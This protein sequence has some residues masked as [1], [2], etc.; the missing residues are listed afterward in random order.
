M[1]SGIISVSQYIGNKSPNKVDLTGSHETGI[2]ASSIQSKSL[3]PTYS[4]SIVPVFQST[5]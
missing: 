3:Y 5:P 4:E 1:V 2:S